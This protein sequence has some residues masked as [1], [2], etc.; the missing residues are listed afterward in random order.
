[1]FS[2][3][4]ERVQEKYFWAKKS[5]WKLEKN[6]KKSENPKDRDFFKSSMSDIFCLWVRI[7]SQAQLFVS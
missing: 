2:E 5:H 6:Q 4:E 7:D 1:M 3:L